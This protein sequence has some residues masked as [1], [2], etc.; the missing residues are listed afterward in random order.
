LDRVDA[1]RHFAAQCVEL[2]HNAQSPRDR[3]LL[4]EIALVWSRLAEFACKI[5]MPKEPTG[6]PA[7]LSPVQAEDVWRV[8]ITWAN[9]SKHRVG[10][11]GTKQEAEK[12]IEDHPWLTEQPVEPPQSSEE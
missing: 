4:I 6:R 9:E 7:I 5:E 2:A 10:K 3:T 8:Q 11:F 12:W 1:Y